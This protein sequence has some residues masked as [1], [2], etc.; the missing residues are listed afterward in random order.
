MTWSEEKAA[1]A[2]ALVE[3]H[4]T[5]REALSA[6]PLALDLY[7]KTSLAKQGALL[8]DALA[9]IE[10]LREFEWMYKELSK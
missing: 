10:R 4:R 3:K 6:T 8:S 5:H 1:R 9:E 2:R 7:D